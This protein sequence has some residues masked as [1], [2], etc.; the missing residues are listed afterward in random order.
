MPALSP[1]LASNVLTQFLVL[2][3]VSG[4][5]RRTYVAKR[6]SSVA[7]NVSGVA[8]SA[9]MAAHLA[10]V[11]PGTEIPAFNARL[12]HVQHAVREVNN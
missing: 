6:V 1:N 11:G 2:R 12:L 10:N 5:I 3:W 8:V 4:E 7:F 9:R